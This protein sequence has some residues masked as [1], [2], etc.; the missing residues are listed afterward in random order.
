MPTFV[1]FCLVSLLVI[2][3]S[4][5][6]RF[7]LVQTLV[8]CSTVSQSLYLSF[9]HFNFSLFRW[10]HYS[11]SVLNKEPLSS[12]SIQTIELGVRALVCVH[13]SFFFFSKNKNV[14]IYSGANGFDNR[15]RWVNIWVC[16]F[17][18]KIWLHNCTTF[19][20]CT[21]CISSTTQM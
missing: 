1:L 19:I 10:C 17:Y 8:L 21:E 13:V 12:H 2:I 15:Y 18:M 11:I 6:R 5:L 7:L 14:L 9:L 3:V 16:C 4:R 20:L